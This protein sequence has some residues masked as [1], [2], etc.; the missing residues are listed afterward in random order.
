MTIKR[1][2]FQ[3]TI[4]EIDDIENG[5][6][7]AIVRAQ[8]PDAWIRPD[9]IVE[10]AEWYGGDETGRV[11]TCRVTHAERGY[12][13]GDGPIW[14]GYAVISLQVLDVADVAAALSGPR[15]VG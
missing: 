11:I 2:R 9:D 1:Y 3:S 14:P 15:E 6:K 10:L 12:R 7:R 5:G 13:D 8:P 4:S